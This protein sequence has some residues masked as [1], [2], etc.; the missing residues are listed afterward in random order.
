MAVLGQLGRILVQRSP[1]TAE[2]HSQRC[3]A[4]IGS[5]RNGRAPWGEDQFRW[6][7]SAPEGP[8]AVCDSLV[9]WLVG[10]LM[11]VVE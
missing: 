9:G 5:E 4:V 11:G 7:L 2:R 8:Y 3:P 10:S 6:R 1:A